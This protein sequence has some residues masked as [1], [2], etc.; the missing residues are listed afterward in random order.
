MVVGPT[1]SGKTGLA[2]KHAKEFN[3]EVISADSRQVYQGLDIGTAKTTKAEMA[4]VT[5]HLIDVTDPENTYSAADFVRDSKEAIANI[6]DRN[7]LPIV[8]GGTFFYV[9][10]L[11]GRTSLPEVPPNPELRDYLETKDAKILY[12]ELQ[13]KDPRRA[14]SVEPEN[15]RRIIRAL[16]IAHELEYVPS[17]EKKE[18]PFEY[19]II[20]IQ[21]EKEEL[22]E[23]FEKRARDWLEQNFLEEVKNLLD[24]GLDRDRLMEIGF[25]YRLGLELLDEEISKEEFIQKFIEKNWQYAR[26]QMSWLKRDNEIKWFASNDPKI[27][28]A[29]KDFLAT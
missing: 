5:H 3:G 10:A 8:A 27:S 12:A 21:I 18:S 11:L 4:G 19:L 1:A 16:E 25:E 20:G 13:K 22:R 26:R 6:N 17:P 2:V 28:E 15:K 9:D 24:S 23:K 29:V 14:A 7:K